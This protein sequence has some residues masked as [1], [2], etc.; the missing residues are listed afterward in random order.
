MEVGDAQQQQQEQQGQ[1]QG[2]TSW[3][4]EMKFNCDNNTHPSYN[5][6]KKKAKGIKHE[7]DE[8]FEGQTYLAEMISCPRNGCACTRLWPGVDENGKKFTHCCRT[9]GRGKACKGN[10]HNSRNKRMDRD[11]ARYEA[12]LAPQPAVVTPSNNS[13]YDGVIC[14]FDAEGNTTSEQE[15]RVMIE[16]D[17]PDVGWESVEEAGDN[18]SVE[19]NVDEAEEPVEQVNAMMGHQIQRVNTDEHSKLLEEHTRVLRDSK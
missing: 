6:A 14:T 18:P 3:R 19:S 17:E 8:K 15:I 2:S 9:C 13:T 1:D 7:E 4:D 12:S 10:Y 16:D 5:H 11:E